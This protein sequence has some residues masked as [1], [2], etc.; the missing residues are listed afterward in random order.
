MTPIYVSSENGAQIDYVRYYCS[1]PS[2]CIWLTKALTK[3]V[4]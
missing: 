4:V 3:N 1:Q 2:C